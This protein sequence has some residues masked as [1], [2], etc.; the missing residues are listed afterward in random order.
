MSKRGNKLSF[1]FCFFIFILFLPQF[2]VSHKRLPPPPPIS[3]DF[4]DPHQ[5]LCRKSSEKLET[6]IN[7]CVSLIKQH[8]KKVVEIP[9]K[10]DFLSCSIL[11]FVR[12]VKQFARKYITGL[13]ELANKLYDIEKSWFHFMP[14][15]IK[16]CL[17]LL[18][19]LVNKPVE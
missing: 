15:V 13:T 8:W 18:R 11:N 2:R 14:C 19:N 4:F 10:R 5:N 17:V 16:N 12:K 9:Q 6:V 1:S 7:T 3:C